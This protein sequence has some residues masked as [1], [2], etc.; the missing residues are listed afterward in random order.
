MSEKSFTYLRDIKNAINFF[1]HLSL[2][3]LGIFPSIFELTFFFKWGSIE[4]L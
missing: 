4:M 1:H 3:H 2:H